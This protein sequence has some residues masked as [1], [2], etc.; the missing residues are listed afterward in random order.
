VNAAVTAIIAENIVILAV[1]GAGWHLFRQGG[2]W[3]LKTPPAPKA[4]PQ[5]QQASGTQMPKASENEGPIPFSR[6]G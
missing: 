6:L 4:S 3:Q 5:P 2:G 1:V